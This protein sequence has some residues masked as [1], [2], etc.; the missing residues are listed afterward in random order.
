MGSERLPTVVC[1]RVG[2]SDTWTQQAARL[3]E[4][5]EVHGT[6]CE[7]MEAASIACVLFHLGQ[8]RAMPIPFVSV[9]DISNNELQATTN[10]ADGLEG[11]SH[12]V[13]KRAA[14]LVRGL[15]ARCSSTLASSSH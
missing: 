8:Q 5:A 3:R 15:I 10:P 9:K 4:L 11:V 7:D 6:A 13:G 12:E 2:S 14:L 1:G